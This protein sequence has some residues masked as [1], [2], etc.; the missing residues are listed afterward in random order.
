MDTPDLIRVLTKAARG[1]LLEW[2]Q[3]DGL[4]ALVQDLWLW[5]RERPSTQEKME[6]LSFPEQVKTVKIHALQLLSEQ[7]LN[8]NLFQGRNLY[9]G[10]AIK[11]AL[12]GKSTNRYLVDILPTALAALEKQNEDHAE[13]IRSRYVAGEV[14]RENA[15]KQSLKRAVRAL[16]EQVNI[17]VITADADAY[18]RCRP[19]SAAAVDPD[20]RKQ[21]GSKPS[22]P[23][24]AIAL[25]LMEFPEL[26]EVFEYELPLDI[27][28]K[29]AYA[30]LVRFDVQR[31]AWVRDVPGSGGPGSLPAREADDAPE[32]A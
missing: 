24:A 21:T 22:D 9:S 12:K 23:T 18:D 30:Q 11:D 28:L 5:W 32:L 2:G 20:T 10:D 16:T 6:G 4:E 14:P 1:A 15:P 19:G 26:R 31:D 27:L 17:I 25:Q 13:A 3:D 8:S 7:T 29:G